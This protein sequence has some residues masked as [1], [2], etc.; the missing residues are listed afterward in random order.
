MEFIAYVTSNTKF[1]EAAKSKQSGELNDMTIYETGIS[2][3]S[4]LFDEAKSDAK[5]I[6]NKVQEADLFAP[7]QLEKSIKVKEL[8][9]ED[10]QREAIRCL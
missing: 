3:L 6:L 2:I 1:I 10:L 9:T 8:D 7:E 4:D 5:S